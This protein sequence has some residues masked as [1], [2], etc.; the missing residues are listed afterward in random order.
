MTGAADPTVSVE[1]TLKRK[2]SAEKLVRGAASGL[3]FLRKSDRDWL[4]VL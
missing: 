4:Q 2:A 1:E 3:Q